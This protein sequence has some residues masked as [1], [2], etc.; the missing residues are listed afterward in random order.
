MQIVFQVGSIVFES[1]GRGGDK[2]G[3]SEIVKIVILW[4]EQI[5]PNFNSTVNFQFFTSIF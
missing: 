4:G 3:T 1:E 5:K 2:K